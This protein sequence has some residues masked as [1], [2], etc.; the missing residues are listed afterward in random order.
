MLIF[1]KLCSPPVRILEAVSLTDQ[2]IPDVQQQTKV[3]S[4]DQSQRY[5]VE[6]AGSYGCEFYLT[7]NRFATPADLLNVIIVVVVDQ[8]AVHCTLGFFQLNK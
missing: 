4:K 6:R 7:S 8:D 3:Q 2:E 1:G 5:S